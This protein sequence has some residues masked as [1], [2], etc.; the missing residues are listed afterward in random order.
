MEI[1]LAIVDDAASMV[2]MG[3]DFLA[4]SE[5]RSLDVTE[6]QMLE[7]I[8]SV[9]SAG[10]SFVAVADA[11]IIGAILGVACPFWFARHITAAIELAWWVAPSHRGSSAG[12]KLLNAFERNAASL[13]IQHI[14]ISDL[15]VGGETPVAKLLA[16]RGYRL[17][18]RMHTKEI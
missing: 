14:G 5:Y 7:G 18:E 10:M 11:Q 2:A 16:R 17:T 8:T 6:G 9:I 15:V 12:L 4:Y 13:G 1:R 3:R